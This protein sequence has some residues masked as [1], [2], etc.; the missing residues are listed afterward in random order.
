M[1]SSSSTS[2]EALQSLYGVLLAQLRADLA[3]QPP[4][5]RLLSKRGLA[6][7][8]GVSERTIKTWRARGLPGH[9]VGRDVMFNV[10]ECDRWIE[11][12]R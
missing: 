3:A 10:R 1:L 6:D 7:H 12:H 11:Q 8:Y 5:P 2:I 9:K 4:Q